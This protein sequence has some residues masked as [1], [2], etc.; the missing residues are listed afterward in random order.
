VMLL[1]FFAVD[2]APLFAP[3]AECALPYCVPA[4]D[5]IAPD[6]MIFLDSVVR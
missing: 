1:V 4:T 3:R 5:S 6:L 2:A